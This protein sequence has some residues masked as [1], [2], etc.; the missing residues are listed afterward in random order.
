MMWKKRLQENNNNNDGGG[1][2]SQQTNSS[3]TTRRSSFSSSSSTP[4][5]LSYHLDTTATSR[6][7][8]GHGSSD[9]SGYLSSM[10]GIVDRGIPSP[11]SAAV[12]GAATTGSGLD[13]PG[14]EGLHHRKSHYHT[15]QQAAAAMM[16]TNNMS[17]VATTTTTTTATVVS[18]ALCSHYGFSMFAT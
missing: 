6:Y 5:P 14:S 4:L 8:I 7:E 12:A 13:S 2:S 15:V 11:S 1:D 18:H 17:N 9:Y 3:T 10:N 16:L